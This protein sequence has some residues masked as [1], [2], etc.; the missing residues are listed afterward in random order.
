M[1]CAAPCFLLPQAAHAQAL[2]ASEAEQMRRHAVTALAAA[3]ESAQALATVSN[4]RD[5]ASDA[6]SAAAQ[7]RIVNT[8]RKLV[9]V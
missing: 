5:A 9:C 4:E 1:L 7:R 8:C 2:A 3:E 6:L